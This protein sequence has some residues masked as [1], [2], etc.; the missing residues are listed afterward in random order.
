MC[1][2][3]VIIP[4]YDRQET[5]IR[6]LKS[7]INQTYKDFEIILIDDGSTDNTH[8]IVD[9]YF[10]SKSDINITHVYQE[11]SGPSKARNFGIKLAK[12]EYIAF[13]DSDDSWKKDKLK[14]QI[15]FLNKNRDVIILGSDFDFFNREIV[16]HFNY[17][18]KLSD[19]YKMLYINFFI[20]PTVIVKRKLFLNNKYLFNE[21]QRY[22]EDQLFFLRIARDYK[23]ARLKLPLTSLYKR[24]SGDG[25]LSD[26]IIM[27]EKNEI[28]NFYTLYKE[29]KD[30][31][32][33]IGVLN[34]IC[35]YIFSIAKFIRRLASKEIYNYIKKLKKAYHER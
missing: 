23:G 8:R 22:A 26:N 19:F 12:G 6:C 34:L 25:G 4:Y 3:S 7:V 2:I 16:K 11:N 28:N 27:L 35:I 1:R 33:N 9:D 30:L 15:E 5:I 14:I 10:E 20:L 21:S 24:Q 29:N 18:F 31:D 32:N 17:K 13:L